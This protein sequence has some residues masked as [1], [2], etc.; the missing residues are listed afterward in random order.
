MD[1]EQVRLFIAPHTPQTLHTVHTHVSSLFPTPRAVA[2]LVAAVQDYERL[3]VDN[4][5]EG[6]EWVEDEFF[7]RN[8]RRK[9]SQN[10]EDAIYGVFA[11]NDSDGSDGGGG[12]GRGRRRRE[13][14]ERKKQDYTKPIGFV[15]GGVMKQ[16]GDAEEEG[17]TCG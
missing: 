16:G 5:Y 10:R 1:E 3:D 14:P 13:A 9:R 11:E 4:D 6:G 15:G 2:T 7:Y 17:P 8:K 12:G